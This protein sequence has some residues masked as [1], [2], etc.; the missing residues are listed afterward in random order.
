MGKVRW[1][2]EDVISSEKS[3]SAVIEEEREKVVEVKL[4]QWQQR[5]GYGC[6]FCGAN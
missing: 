1:P 5:G 3:A 4:C 2:Y 6:G